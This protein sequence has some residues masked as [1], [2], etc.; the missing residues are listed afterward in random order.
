M[1]REAVDSSPRRA[2]RRAFCKKKQL[3][4]IMIICII[5]ITIIIIS[6]I[7]CIICMY[8]YIYTYLP[9]VCIQA[10]IRNK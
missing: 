3:I 5:I 10:Y 1:R 6:S 2:E 9:T 7:S 8:I 4:H